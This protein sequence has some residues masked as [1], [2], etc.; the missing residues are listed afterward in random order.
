MSDIEKDAQKDNEAR[1][2]V[3]QAIKLWIEVGYSEEEI[4]EFV[5]E[6]YAEEA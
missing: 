3:A 6:I 1:R 2:L 4:A 5:S